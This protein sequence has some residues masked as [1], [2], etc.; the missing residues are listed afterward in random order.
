MELQ[1]SL[2]G[3]D[4]EKSLQKLQSETDILSAT[5]KGTCRQH[6]SY[7]IFFYKIS[8]QALKVQSHDFFFFHN[9]F[10]FGEYIHVH[11]V[12]FKVW[13]VKCSQIMMFT[14]KISP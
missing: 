6:I 1:D 3:P 2:G 8:K 14:L 5:G 4:Q 11:S 10:A 12:V 7:Y 9:K 13:F